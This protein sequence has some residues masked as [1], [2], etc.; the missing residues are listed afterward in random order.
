MEKFANRLRELRKERELTLEHMGEAMGL[1]YTTYAGYEKDEIEP[2]LTNLVK[3][4]DFFGVTTD[5]LLGRTE[6]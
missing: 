1:H 6:I 4:A 3:L 5:Y 2:N